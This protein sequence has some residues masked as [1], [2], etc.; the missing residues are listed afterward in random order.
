M[1]VTLEDT[2]HHAAYLSD[3]GDCSGQRLAYILKRLL[4]SHSNNEGATVQI[5]VVQCIVLLLKG[6]HADSFAVTILKA[7]IAGL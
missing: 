4:L 3:D 2:S 1:K 5:A 6:P 7:N